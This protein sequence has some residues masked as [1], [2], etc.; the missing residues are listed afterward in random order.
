[1]K[2]MTMD[3]RQKINTGKRSEGNRN[4]RMIEMIIPHQI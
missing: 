3:E 4:M 2:G 1:M